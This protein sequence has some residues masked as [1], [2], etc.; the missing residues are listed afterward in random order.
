MQ[1]LFFRLQCLV[2]GCA[3][4]ECSVA[5][6]ADSCVMFHKGAPVRAVCGRA[7]N[8]AGE[9][10]NNVALTLTGETGSVLFT[11]WSDSKGSFSFSSIPNGDYTLHAEAPGYRV[12]K[13]E[14]RVTN[15]DEEKCSPKIDV[16]LGFGSCDTGTYVKG[17]DKPSDLDSEF[18]Q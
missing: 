18:R 3:L 2:I 15:T 5:S 1:G 10:L 4:L 9:K 7:T 13:R 8:R 16:T 6:H 14:I 17:V 11:T 12:A